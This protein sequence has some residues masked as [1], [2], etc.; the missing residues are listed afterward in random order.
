M[1]YTFNEKQFLAI[2]SKEP[3][4]VI[5]APAG[6][7]KTSTL[8]G[9][10]KKY[11]EENPL[12]EVVAITFTRKS[13][14]DLK[15]KLAGYKNVSTSTIHSWSYQQLEKI[16]LER[17]GAKNSFT[18][19][20]LPDDKIKEILDD[21]CK[22]RRYFY[23]KKNE[24]FFFI[25]GNYNIDIED[26]VRRTYES[27]KVEY[28]LFKRNN[29]LYDFTDLP[30]FLL[31]KMNDYSI[32]IKGIDALF[33][34][35]FQDVD[36][37]QLE[38]FDRVEAKKK[39]YIGDPQ[40]SIYQF[41][42]ATPEVLEKLQNFSRMGLDVNYRSYQEIIDFASSY[43]VIASLEGTMFSNIIESYPSSII[44]ERGEG[45]KVYSMNKSGAAYEVNKFIKLRGEDLVAKLIE[46]HVMILCRKNK[47]V[48]AIQEL[49]YMN[50]STIHQA[51]G[52]EYE[53]VIVTDFEING[54]ED[55]NIAYV[56]MTRAEDILLAASYAALYKILKRFREEGFLVK[57][58]F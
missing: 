16:G 6:S 1:N 29:G 32:N 27:I 45:G 51:K 5:I 3:N 37:I 9:A 50:V 57:S 12:S 10:I 39:F 41:R 23:I 58:L 25:M 14:E 52:L 49:G 55:I 40:Q 15:L 18:K 54:E 21:I 48:K 36:E 34:D 46:K 24:L 19:K 47:E 26:S 56:G 35:E 7:G 53:N 20:I 13:A 2:Q 42:G 44:C 28:I 8:V 22:S 38:V 11:K 31:D 33:V 17:E 43:Q 30:E 4:V